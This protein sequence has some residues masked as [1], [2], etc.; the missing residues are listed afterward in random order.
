MNFYCK[1]WFHGKPVCFCFIFLIPL[2]FIENKTD[3]FKLRL[4]NKNSQICQIIPRF[5]FLLKAR[6]GY[7]V[8][9][10]SFVSTGK[11]LLTAHQ[12]KNWMNTTIPQFIVLYFILPCQ[13]CIFYKLKIFGNPASSKSFSTL[14]PILFAQFTSLCYILIILATAAAF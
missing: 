3:V 13:Y 1:H 7:I 5:F 14:F 9:F 4:L 12:L 6:F 11:T 8:L 10:V 2:I